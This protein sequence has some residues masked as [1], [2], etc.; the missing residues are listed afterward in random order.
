MIS[1]EKLRSIRNDLPMDITIARL[2]AH[3]PPAKM[4]EGYFRF[5]CPHCGELQATVN[6][7]NNL[8]H[9]FCCE[10]NLNNIDLLIEL[11][12]DFRAAVALL[13]QWLSQQQR[14]PAS[15]PLPA[16]SRLASNS[17]ASSTAPASS[18]SPPAKTT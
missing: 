18:N 10:K 5:L 1:P 11:G 9:C 15:R 12:Y 4:I 14:N 3:A 16:A 13:D 2:G 8:A 6:P 17:P 7:K